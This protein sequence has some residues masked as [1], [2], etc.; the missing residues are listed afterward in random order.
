MNRIT[1][2]FALLL[3]CFIAVAQPGGGQP[4]EIFT[5]E[6]WD[7]LSQSQKDSINKIFTDEYIQA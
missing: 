4:K 5:Q 6:D 2:L 7:K 1:A 3:V